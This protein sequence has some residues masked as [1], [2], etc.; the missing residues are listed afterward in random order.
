MRTA[1][2]T[3][4]QSKPKP[5]VVYWRCPLTSVFVGKKSSCLHLSSISHCP[6]WSPRSLTSGVPVSVTAQMTWQ[7]VSVCVCMCLCD[8]ICLCIFVCKTINARIITIHSLWK[9]VFWIGASFT[10]ARLFWILVLSLPCLYTYKGVRP[11][12]LS[13]SAGHLRHHP[14][15]HNVHEGVHAPALRHQSKYI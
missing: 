5:R 10:L 7:T 4:S 12:S 14:T 2:R 6:S 13:P 9:C 11:V 15:R 1:L 8:H 3:V